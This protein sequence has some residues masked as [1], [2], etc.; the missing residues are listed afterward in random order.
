MNPEPAKNT[1]ITLEAITQQKAD[2]LMKI[3]EQKSI[4]TDLTRDLFA[5]LAPAANKTNAVVRA[6]NTGVAVFDGVMLGMKLMRKF[7]SV[8]GRKYR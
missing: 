1:P 8:L 7:R 6:F 4:M 2:L 5:P 3:H